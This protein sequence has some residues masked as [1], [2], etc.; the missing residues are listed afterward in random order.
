MSKS[1]GEALE[2]LPELRLAVVGDLML[3]RFIFGHLDQA[4]LNETHIKRS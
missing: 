2:R 1:L 4:V 3:D